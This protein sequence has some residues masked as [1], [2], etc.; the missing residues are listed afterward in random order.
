M[1]LDTVEMA[2]KARKRPGFRVGLGFILGLGWVEGSSVR[3]DLG[4]GWVG[5][6]VG[7]RVLFRV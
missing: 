2:G 1:A 4:A 7:F 6:K 3:I 5:V